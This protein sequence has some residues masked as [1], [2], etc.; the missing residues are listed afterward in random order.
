MSAIRWRRPV[1]ARAVEA[2]PDGRLISLIR[3]LLL[4]ESSLY[5]A[6][7]PVLPHYAHSLHASKPAV[8]L[9]AAAYPAGLIPGSLIGG[10]IASRVGV[11]R[12]TF[13]GLIA[14]GAAIAAFGFGSDLVAL[15]LLR[16]IQGAS[17]GLIWGGGL[18]WA[19]AVAPRERRGAVIGSVIAAATFGTLLGPLLGTAAVAV[20]TRPVFCLLG[21]ISL[22]LAMITWR[23]PEPGHR[24]QAEP[25]RPLSRAALRAALRGG[26]GMGIWLINLEAITIGATNVLLPLRLSRFGASGVAIGATFLLAAALSSVLSPIVGRVTDRRGTRAPVVVGLIASAV[27]LVALLAPRSALLLA[28]LCVIALGAPLTGYMIPAVSMMTDSAERAGIAL[29]LATTLVNLSYATGETIGAPL[30]AGLSQATSDAVPVL[31]IAAT[32][33]I[34]LPAV[35]TGDAQRHHGG[36]DGSEGSGGSDGPTAEG[37]PS[38]GSS[39]TSRATSA[40]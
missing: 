20:G 25:G 34:T 14:F 9:L 15:D 36:R 1:S 8:G 37:Q 5:S 31:L 11:R 28:A 22:V 10:W 21:A 29:V 16:V 17:C 24:P 27:L 13:A 4:F 38:T 7:T 19:I 23:H 2:G 39:V 40:A 3:W 32:M 12:T 26:L 6:V 18:T 33:L 30:A 35:L